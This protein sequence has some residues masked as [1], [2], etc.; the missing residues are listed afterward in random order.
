MA[1]LCEVDTFSNDTSGLQVHSRYLSLHLKFDVS[2]VLT[3][4]YQKAF[5]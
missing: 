1:E 3:F 5:V 2:E 4:D